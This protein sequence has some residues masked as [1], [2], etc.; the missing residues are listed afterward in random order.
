M[1]SHSLPGPAEVQ[2]RVLVLRS[3]ASFPLQFWHLCFFPFFSLQYFLEI[4]P[5]C[6]GSLIQWGPASGQRINKLMWSHPCTFYSCV[7]WQLVLGAVPVGIHEQFWECHIL[8]SNKR[9]ARSDEKVESAEKKKVLNVSLR[10]CV[11]VTSQ[12][13]INLFN[14]R[15]IFSK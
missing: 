4:Q 9:E 14:Y 13:F 8:T 10:S 6:W 11:M 3:T 2:M 15:V 12:W 5:F 7:S 1:S